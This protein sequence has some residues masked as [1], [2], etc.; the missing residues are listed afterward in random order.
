MSENQTSYDQFV[1]VLR[2]A[3]A[4]IVKGY[5]GNKAA[6]T[7]GRKGLQ[8]ARNLLNECRKDLLA[9]GKGPGSEGG[10]AP[11]TVTARLGEA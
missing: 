4:D 10:V 11:R 8:E 7:R 9:A 3:E 6:S 2:A 5:G 1:A